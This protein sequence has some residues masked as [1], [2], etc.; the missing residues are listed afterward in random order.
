MSRSNEEDLNNNKE[1]QI[2]ERID[3]KNDLKNDNS[4][5]NIKQA[6]KTFRYWRITLILFL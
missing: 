3:N 2:T 4:K 5:N 1:N 6:I